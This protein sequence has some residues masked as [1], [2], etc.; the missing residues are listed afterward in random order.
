M[1]IIGTVGVS[2]GAFYHYCSIEE[3]LLDALADRG[4]RGCLEMIRGIAEDP[5]PPAIEKLNRVL[6]A[7][8]A[9]K[10][11]SHG[12]REGSFDLAQPEKAATAV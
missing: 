6:A 3:E 7:S 2:K 10:A 1:S 8:M 9:F 12:V 4:G 5:A 11:R